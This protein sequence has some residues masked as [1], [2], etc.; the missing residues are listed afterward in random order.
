MMRYV[1]AIFLL[2]ILP[3]FGWSQT[4]SIRSGEHDGFTRLVV[5]LPN[6]VEAD[7]T[8][9][10]AGSEVT[11]SRP[12]SFDIS[13]IYDR[14]GR[15]RFQNVS[16]GQG[17][18]VLSLSY[19]CDCQLRK[20]VLV[21]NVL[22]LD[23]VGGEQPP[24][25]VPEPQVAAPVLPVVPETPKPSLEDARRLTEAVT[26]SM[27]KPGPESGTNRLARLAELERAMIDQVAR[28]ATQGL[29]DIAEGGV[30]TS[31]PEKPIEPTQEKSA[32]DTEPQSDQKISGG[33]RVHTSLLSEDETTAPVTSDGVAC[34]PGFDFTSWTE[35]GDFNAEL[36]AR[37]A[38]VFGE[39]DKVDDKSALDLAKFYLAFGFGAEALRA[40]DLMI[41]PEPDVRVLSSLA[42]IVDLGHDPRP[43]PLAGMTDCDSDIALWS[44][45]ASKP[46]LHETTVAK[47][48]VLRALNALPDGLRKSLGPELAERFLSAG[49]TETSQAVMRILERSDPAQSRDE[50]M[51]SGLIDLT[52]D[53]PEK[54]RD[55]LTDVVETASERSPA[56][57]IALIDDT[58]S[59]VDPIDPEI[60]ELAGAYIVEYRTTPLAND[61]AKAE[62]RA[63]AAAGQF[64]A[65]FSLLEDRLDQGL[66][67][68]PAVLRSEI[69][70][71]VLKVGSDEQ[72]LRHG[73]NL[74]QNHAEDLSPQVS[75]DLAEA[76]RDLGFP[77][78]AFQ[79]SASL[80]NIADERGR[81]VRAEAA[82]LAG[83]PQRAK[84]ELIGVE[85]PEADALR[86]RAQ[87]AAGD[88]A[89]ASQSYA[90]TD[91]PD[92]AEQSAWRAGDWD[93]L[94]GSDDTLNAALSTL[95]RSDRPEPTGGMIATNRRLLQDTRASRET[96][97]QM[98]DRY[99]IAEQ[100]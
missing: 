17:G 19:E 43:S 26:M 24:T 29:L 93:Q 80:T 41:N 5:Y 89:A 42:R 100:E 74:A 4:V 13:G 83:R 39:F 51:I 16:I 47:S 96:L 54:G 92:L 2:V 63:R 86:A 98:L 28:T 88:F 85:G 64:E 12:V 10:A 75:V 71:Y 27:P 52:K 90:A 58:L 40:M 1:A 57:L 66:V 14:I 25:V 94:Q 21:G 73:L 97:Q 55:Q 22:V 59:R 35:A 67:T 87:E 44:V 84:A 60:A 30:E 31:T 70:S 65:A 79:L 78:V 61:L 15:D 95:M 82:L 77:D 7:V 32:S 62:L 9:T 33:A 69:A 18:K 81:L 91:Q 20:E 45:L 3:N 38:K 76:L 49:D 48:A 36:G 8:R 46:L 34:I 50:K 11:T 68:E 53:E 6:G 37:R 72:I 99:A 56:A 23:L